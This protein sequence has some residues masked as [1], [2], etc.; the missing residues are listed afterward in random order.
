MKR[1]L[2]K[3]LCVIRRDLQVPK[4]LARSAQ[5]IVAPREIL[6]GLKAIQDDGIPSLCGLKQEITR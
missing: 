2:K 6:H 1:S 4:D 5:M 3:T